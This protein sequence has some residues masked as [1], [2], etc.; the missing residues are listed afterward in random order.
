[1]GLAG[2]QKKSPLAKNL[3]VQTGKDMQAPLYSDDFIQVFVKL[4]HSIFYNTLE[5][6]EH[7]SAYYLHTNYT[8]AGCFL[9]G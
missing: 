8:L 3:L 7:N 9:A 6:S 1:M 4:H 5:S 2:I